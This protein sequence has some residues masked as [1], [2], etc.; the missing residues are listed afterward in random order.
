MGRSGFLLGTSAEGARWGHVLVSGRTQRGL[1][2]RLI[3]TRNRNR[4]GLTRL[5]TARRLAGQAGLDAESVNERHTENERNTD[6]EWRRGRCA[7]V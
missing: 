4:R 3:L 7:E 5:L 2:G 6:C 1:R